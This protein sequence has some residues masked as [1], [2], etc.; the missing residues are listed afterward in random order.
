MKRLTITDIRN[1]IRSRLDGAEDFTYRD[2]Y[3]RLAETAIDSAQPSQICTVIEYGCINNDRLSLDTMCRLFD[4]LYEYGDVSQIKKYGNSILKEYVSRVRDAKETQTYLKKKLGLAKSKVTTKIQNNFDDIKD[5]FNRLYS[6][7]KSNLNRNVKQISSVAKKAFP[8]N[9]MVKNTTTKESA[10]IGIYESMVDKTTEM[11]SIDR[12]LENYNRISKR[13]NIDRIIQEN[14]M[15][16]GIEDTIVEICELIDT[17]DMSVKA[18]YN[19]CLET[20][21]YGLHK[22]SFSFSESELVTTVTNYYM[23]HGKNGKACASILE[24]STVFDKK[25]YMG[26]IDILMEEE[27]EETVSE[28]KMDRLYRVTY[29]GVGIYEAFKNACT[30]DEWKSFKNSDAVKWLPVPKAYGKDTNNTSYFT[31]LGYSKFKKNVYPIITQKLDKGSIKVD[32]VTLSTDPIYSD[33]YQVVVPTTIAR[34][35]S[36]QYM[37]MDKFILPERYFKEDVE[38]FKDVKDYFYY[39]KEIDDIN[40]TSSQ[41]TPS[42]KISMIRNPFEAIATTH[43][44]K[45]N[46][47]RLEAIASCKDIVSEFNAF[48]DSLFDEMTEHNKHAIESFGSVNFKKPQQSISWAVENMNKNIQFLQD[49]EG[50]SRDEAYRIVKQNFIPESLTEAGCRSLINIRITRNRAFTTCLKTLV[51]CNYQFLNL[52]EAEASSLASKLDNANLSSQAIETIKDIMSKKKTLRNFKVKDGVYDFRD[53]GG[54]CIFVSP[55][56]VDDADMYYESKPD[57]HLPDIFEYDAIV[58]SHGG[59][60]TDTADDFN[61]AINNILDNIENTIG[62]EYKEYNDVRSQSKFI[63]ETDSKAINNEIQKGSYTADEFI[64]KFILKPRT[65]LYKMVTEFIKNMRSD[66]KNAITYRNDFL[67]DLDDFEDSH[68]L[69]GQLG[70]WVR[71]LKTEVNSILPNW[72][73]SYANGDTSGNWT[74]NP[75]NTLRADRIS[76]VPELIR[77][78]KKEGFKTILLTCCNPGSIKLPNDIVK[79]HSIRVFMGNHSVYKENYTTDER[80]LDHVVRRLD[81]QIDY[82]IESYNIDVITLQPID[83]LVEEYNEMYTL[84]MTENAID[85]LTSLAKKAIEIIVSLW[86]GLIS[87]VKYIIQSIKEFIFGPEKSGNSDAKLSKPIEM[88]VITVSNGKPDVVT[89]SISSPKEAKDLAV[90]SSKKIES[91]VKSM[92]DKETAE[93]KKIQDAIDSGKTKVKDKNGKEATSESYIREV[94]YINDDGEDVPKV[95]PECGADVKVYLKGEPVFVC[96][97]KNCSKYFG[98]VPF[99]EDGFDPFGFK[100]RREE[101]ERLAKIADEEIK[102]YDSAY[103]SHLSNIAKICANKVEYMTITDSISF[104]SMYGAYVSNIATFV[105]TNDMDNE[106]AEKYG[107]GSDKHIKATNGL[108][109]NAEKKMKTLAT[110]VDDYI[111]KHNL[112]GRAISRAH[113]DYVVIEIEIPY[114]NTSVTEAKLTSEQRAKLKDS[115]YGIPSKKKYPMPDESHVRSAIQMFN[116][117]SSEDEAELAKNIKKNI[118][119]Y[120]MSV[121]VGKEN[122]FS[123]YYTS[124]NETATI[125]NAIREYATGNKGYPDITLKEATDFNKILDDFKASNSEHK[126]SKLKMLVSKLY[127]KNVDNIVDGTPSLLSYI[128]TFFIIGT[129][130]VPV[131]GPVIGIVAF[132]ADRIVALHMDRENTLKMRAAFQKEIRATDKKIDSTKDSEK[133]SRLEEYRKS[134]MD[135]YDKID[136]YYSDLLSEKEMDEKFENPDDDDI[137]MRSSGSMGGDDFSDFDFGDD[138]NDFDDDDDF[139]NMDE[140]SRYIV[141]TSKLAN[142]LEFQ[143]IHKTFNQEACRVMISKY[144]SFI[145]ELA[146]VAIKFPT[147]ID[148]KDLRRSI[149]DIRSDAKINNMH[150][151]VIEKYDLDNAYNDLDRAID[152]QKTTRPRDI[153]FESYKLGVAIEITRTLNEVYSSCMYYSPIV[154]ASFMNTIK[155]ASE[156]LKQSFQKLSDKEKT[157]SRNLDVSVNNFAKAAEKS[158]TDDNREAILKGSVLPKASKIVKLAIANIGIGVL[159][160][161]VV[162][163]IGTLG[164]LGVSAHMKNKQKRAILDEIEVELKMCQKYIDLAESKNDLK[165]LKKLYTIQRSLERQKAKIMYNLKTKGESYHT[166][167]ELGNKY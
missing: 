148:P 9:P 83:V 151:S 110:K 62:H 163:V 33:L 79:D 120:G 75:V 10:Y 165:S 113:D 102:K 82:L 36:H 166:T 11:V 46:N 44:E 2:R 63:S 37:D 56:D 40:D 142:I 68:L 101:R 98:T 93:I 90:D 153:T 160:D 118:K 29:N 50:I 109:M 60:N 73:S 122:R 71:W 35:S 115:D 3:E 53:V 78:L 112:P 39:G 17:Y 94:K 20:C 126:E 124:S 96:S 26:D 4:A 6:G 167:E 54:G 164:Y 105:L 81:R 61:D 104:E 159:I 32:E 146:D 66:R 158:M 1:R 154:E 42:T 48:F 64:S 28:G 123:K 5:A 49:Y 76:T 157:I 87:V 58:Y 18:R 57:K 92:S 128:R 52:T 41:G 43:P 149:D 147:I 139:E 111:S 116:H 108:L 14:T 65:E 131:I 152:N 74:V 91:L 88:T 23:T 114:E 140:A 30:Y 19:T 107:Y 16:N 136:E 45:I 13:F 125:Q 145:K 103:K 137:R 8:N 70:N 34:E 22:N 77:Q 133:R 97:N 135:A 38:E 21:W 129:F 127:S 143:C 155:L 106:F 15:V 161:P 31:E 12:I 99:K 7:G 141:Y 100:K 69:V 117:V 130:A 51:Q 47:V 55:S 150:I 95:C 25:D 89:K 134:L 121:D 84:Y 86:K 119:Q 156:K 144:P 132:I 72:V 85:V 80:E 59:Y 27:P 67:D 24:V 162:A 138:L